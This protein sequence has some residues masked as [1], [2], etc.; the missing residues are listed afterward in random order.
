M[1]ALFF[2]LPALVFLLLLILIPIVGTFLISL[3]RVVSFSSVSFIGFENYVRLLNDPQFFKSLFFTL[4]FTFISV[5]T[6]ILLGL[7]VAL[8]INEK[9]PLRGLLR[10]IAL[11]PWVV[12]SV[13]S[14]KV[15]ALMFNYT[16]GFFNWI[17]FNV[18][19][20]RINWLGNEITAFLSLIIADVWRTTPFVAIILLAGLQSI[21]SEL[22]NQAKIDGASLFKR[23][24]YITL[25]L[26]KPFILIALLFRCVDALRVFDIVFVIT[27]GGPGGAT[28]SL[29]L[30]A[31]RYYLMGDMGYGSALSVVLF[32]IALTFSLVFLKIWKP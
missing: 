14:G 32:F 16:Y 2:N 22:Y 5:S 17:T 23:F 15:W 21:P 11:L 25:P 9:I 31:Y 26:L 24:F 13:V 7:F 3:F 6:E 12:P 1:T 10:G 18:I 8:L 20:E 28:E 29:T 30:Y 4:N 19:G 27:G